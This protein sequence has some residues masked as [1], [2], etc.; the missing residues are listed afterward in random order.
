MQAIM[1]PNQLTRSKL[2]LNSRAAAES[3]LL[4]TPDGESYKDNSYTW[5]CNWTK[6]GP[7]QATDEVQDTLPGGH[8]TWV[9][10]VQSRISP[11]PVQQAIER[12]RAERRTMPTNP[13]NRRL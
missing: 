4:R 9:R 10:G 12:D 2:M 13:T 3:S 1:F 11:P 6:P 8:Q 7:G 5:I